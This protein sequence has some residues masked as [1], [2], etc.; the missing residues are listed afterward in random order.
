MAIV[1]PFV[2]VGR[3][4]KIFNFQTRQRSNKRN[5]APQMQDEIFGAQHDKETE[6]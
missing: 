6:I 5:P 1:M 4:L 2:L 3:G